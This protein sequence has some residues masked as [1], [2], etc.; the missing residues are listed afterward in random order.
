MGTDASVAQLSGDRS[1]VTPTGAERAVA[2]LSHHLGSDDKSA[3]GEMAAVARLQRRT[4]PEG[5]CQHARVDTD[6]NV[7]SRHSLSA[8]TNRSHSSSVRSSIANS[9]EPS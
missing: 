5:R 6:G 7:A 4:D 8:A 1:T 2:S 9:P 3:T